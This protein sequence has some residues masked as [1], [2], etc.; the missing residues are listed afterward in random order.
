LELCH[1]TNFPQ[2]V[3]FSKKLSYFPSKEGLLATGERVYQF[4]LLEGKTIGKL[5]SQQ[6]GVYHS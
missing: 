4:H 1:W 3:C 5:K 6:K 2:K